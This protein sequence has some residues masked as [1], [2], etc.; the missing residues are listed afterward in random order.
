MQT[1][2]WDKGGDKPKAT[3]SLGNGHVMHRGKFWN[4]ENVF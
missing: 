4:K 3:V 1:Y 2:H